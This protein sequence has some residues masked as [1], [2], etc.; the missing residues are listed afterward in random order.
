M[1]AKVPLNEVERVE[2]KRW[3]ELNFLKNKIMASS[4]IMHGKQ[5]GKNGN[6]DSNLWEILMNRD[7]WHAAV[8]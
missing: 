5:M 7:A 1:G 6:S 4:P 2:C 3:L 8:H